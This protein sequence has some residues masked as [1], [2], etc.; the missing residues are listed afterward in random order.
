MR[1]AVDRRRF[2][3]SGLAGAVATASAGA[4]PAIIASPRREQLRLGLI[5]T[6]MRG[7]VLLSSLV[8]RD[9]VVV[10]ALCDIEPIMLNKANAIIAKAGKPAARQY[11]ADGDKD[12][13]RRLLAD[14][15]L[16]AVI[17]ATPWEWHAP[18]AIARCR[19]R[20]RSAAR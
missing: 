7:Q 20:S 5:G 3:K 1:I 13:W 15:A 18:M 4:S 9:D 12:A 19:R 2:L 16:D 17:I 11:G 6:G 10:T 14:R 8:Q